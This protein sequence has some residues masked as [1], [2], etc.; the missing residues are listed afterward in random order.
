M[1]STLPPGKSVRA[2]AFKEQRWS[3]GDEAAV[4]Q[5]AL[6]TRCM[7]RGVQQLDLDVGPTFT[8]SP[9]SCEV[10]S[11]SGMPVMRENPFRLMG[12]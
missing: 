12:N 7:A 6:T 1:S 11:P 9:W 2:A 10:R 8:L 4:E 3:T 5:K